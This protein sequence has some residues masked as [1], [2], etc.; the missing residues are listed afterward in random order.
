MGRKYRKF[1]HAKKSAATSDNAST[2]EYSSP[3]VGL[4]DQIFTFGKAKDSAKFKVLKEELGRQFATQTLNNG[5]DSARAFE[6][7]KDTVYI[8]PSEPSLPT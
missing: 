5:A 7:S 1:Y 2:T 4:Q 6:T 3:T 8:K